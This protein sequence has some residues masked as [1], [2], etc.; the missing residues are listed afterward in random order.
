MWSFYNRKYTVNQKEQKPEILQK[1]RGVTI[2][3]LDENRVELRTTP[4]WREFLMLMFVFAICALL[5]SGLVIGFLSTHDWIND[6]PV[7]LILGG[8]GVVLLT[9]LV[10]AMVWWALYHTLHE[11]FLTD[12]K[13]RKCIHTYC[14][15]FR[16]EIP[17]EDVEYIEE[18][19]NQNGIGF[20]LKEKGKRWRTCIFFANAFTKSMCAPEAAVR[21]F[22]R[23]FEKAGITFPGRKEGF[24]SKLEGNIKI[25]FWI[26]VFIAIFIGLAILPV[27]DLVMQ[28]VEITRSRPTTGI[29][30]R[31]P[32]EPRN[33][34]S[35]GIAY[36]YTIN[37]RRY[38]SSRLIPEGIFSV[39]T[40][41]RAESLEDVYAAGD[42]VT[43]HYDPAMP[44]KA[45]LI[46]GW[47]SAALVIV[48][49]IWGILLIL[50]AQ[51][52]KEKKL[53]PMLRAFLLSLGLT[54]LVHGIGTGIACASVGGKLG[55]AVRTSEVHWYLLAFAG[56][57]AAWFAFFALRSGKYFSRRRGGSR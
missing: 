2:V 44:E 52:L 6:P 5:F 46:H 9:G 47:N 24:L 51:W 29:I 39:D 22:T 37:G 33:G 54:V 8:I 16:R 26:I 36:T 35:S 15:F 30:E 13:S 57:F 41:Q 25:V 18:Y 32:E 17:F 53:R 4:G 3:R 50:S 45:H 21:I 48:S 10:L 11:S 38:E 31:V 23:E 1:D 7:S 56:L 12:T 55:Q 28:T 40:E 43:I 42:E 20:Y 49:F 27:V 19:S 34:E 14:R